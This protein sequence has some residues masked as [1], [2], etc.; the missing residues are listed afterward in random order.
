MRIELRY[1]D[2]A[3]RKALSTAPDLVR[4]ML[5]QALYRGADALRSDAY[6][7]AA[8]RDATG[9]L[10]RGIAITKVSELHL[11]VAPSDIYG[12]YVERGRRPGKLPGIGVRDWV[13]QKLK[14]GGER[15]IDRLDWVI[16]AAIRK[17]GIP[18]RP[19]MQP[20]FEAK[21]GRV[22]DLANAAMRRA[23]AQ[24]NGGGNGV[25]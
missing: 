13:K 15:E 1:D 16:S 3:A 20:A 22:V 25:A 9:Q 19:F 12:A 11:F 24:I 4:R 21:K 18:P 2:A 14:P 17:R 10:S 8:K 6:N 5:G 7:R 23:V